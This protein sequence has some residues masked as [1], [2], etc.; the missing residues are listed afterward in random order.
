MNRGITQPKLHRAAPVFAVVLT[1]GACA[2]EPQYGEAVDV[3]S[4]SSALSH[5]GGPG[6]QFRTLKPNVGY[7]EGVDF[8]ISSPTPVGN[9]VAHVTP[10]AVGAVDSACTAA[11]FAGFPA[12]D[13]ALVRRGSC[14][15]ETKILNAI[16]AG[17]RGV[18]FV[19]NVPGLSVP[20]VLSATGVPSLL[21]RQDL[22]AELAAMPDLRVHILVRRER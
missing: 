17:A 1:C 7:E 14:L 4:S 5:T 3:E 16:A 6:A 21:I 18:I 15:F 13:V 8:V 10:V 19:N 20:H 11:D 12:G 2:V 9:V 22:G